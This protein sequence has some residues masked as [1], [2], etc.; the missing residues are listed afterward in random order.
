MM[1]NRS[2]D[3]DPSVLQVLQEKHGLTTQQSID[4][5]N[6]ES[7]F[8]GVAGN[9]DSLAIEKMFAEGD[10]KAALAV[11]MFCYRIAKYVASYT[12]TL[13]GPIAILTFTGGI[14]EKSPLKRERILKFLAPLGFE[15]DSKLNYQ[16]GHTETGV[17]SCSESSAIAMVVPTNEELVIAQE[18]L[19]LVK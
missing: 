5:L 1:G 11:D 17:I 18:T 6:L 7:G 10:A 8:L 9:A 19:K 16:N 4:I 2:G 13:G 3:I 12:V 15:V 14:G